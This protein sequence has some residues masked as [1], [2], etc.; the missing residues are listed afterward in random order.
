[1]FPLCPL[2]LGVPCTYQWAWGRIADFKFISVPKGFFPLRFLM[3]NK[4][5]RTSVLCAAKSWC[6]EKLE[7]VIRTSETEPVR[8]IDPSRAH[9]FSG[10]DDADPGY[11][12]SHDFEEEAS[13]QSKG[14]SE[15]QE[16]WSED[17][18]WWGPDDWDSSWKGSEPWYDDI[19]WWSDAARP[20]WSKDNARWGES[21]TQP[22]A[23][24]VLPAEEFDQEPEAPPGFT[25]NDYSAALI[26]TRRSDSIS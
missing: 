5:Q 1:M 9:G 11:S 6:F 15:W 21:W 8:S 24:G 16:P 22:V 23:E 19:A 2:R 13:V 12:D 17:W 18:A 3:F 26:V 7:S 25:D 14:T 20:V 10:E 4:E